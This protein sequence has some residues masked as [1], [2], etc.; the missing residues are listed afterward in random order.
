LFWRFGW[1]LRILRLQTIAPQELAT[2]RP[3]TKKYANISMVGLYLFWKCAKIAAMI[4]NHA[5][6][7][8]ER[9]PRMNHRWTR[10]SD[11]AKAVCLLLQVTV[12]RFQVEVGKGSSSPC[13]IRVDPGPSVVPIPQGLRWLERPGNNAF[14]AHSD[15]C[16]Y[17]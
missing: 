15:P 16:Q 11:P 2:I 9:G 10:V 5:G 12:R 14:D 13:L 3:I 8:G 7:G 6:K 1:F 4:M 17:K